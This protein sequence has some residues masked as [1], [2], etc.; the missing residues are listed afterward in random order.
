MYN[1]KTI[2]IIHATDADQHLGHLR[3]IL[4]ELKNE[5]RI[6]HYNTLESEAVTESSFK[7]LGDDDMVI[8]LLTQ[9]IEALKA[10]IRTTLLTV[11]TRKPDAKMAQIIIDHLAYETKFIAFPADLEPIRSREDM[12]SVWNQI[13]NSL[14]T[15]SSSAPAGRGG[16]RR[17]RAMEKIYSIYCRNYRVGYTHFVI[18]KII[19]EPKGPDPI[20]NPG[21]IDNYSDVNDDGSDTGEPQNPNI[22][23][24]SRDSYQYKIRKIGETFWMLENMRFTI[25]G[26]KCNDC[27]TKGRHYNLNM[28]KN[29]CPEGWTLPTINDFNALS[30]AGGSFNGT[31]S[32]ARIRFNGRFGRTSG[33]N[34]FVGVGT[35]AAFWTNSSQGN[36]GAH[37]F[38]NRSANISRSDV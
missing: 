23:T 21:P 3:K 31:V 32:L 37:F 20:D 38:F 33:I 29:V 13:A 10:E 9:G 30:Q 17:Y 1:P 28:A 22:L 7:A 36:N 25:Q 5:K 24:D 18:N 2:Q 35:F 14:R 19:S 15:I 16:K 34:D 8:M 27:K 11:K 26:S 4:D 12:D 6:D